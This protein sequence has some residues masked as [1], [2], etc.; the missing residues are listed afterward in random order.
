VIYP[1]P[2]SP[3]IILQNKENRVYPYLLRG[4]VIDRPDQVWCADITYIRMHRGWVYLMAIMDWFS[5]YVLAWEVSITLDVSFCLTAMARALGMG[6]P[7][8]FNTDQGSQFTSDGFTTMLEDIG[9]RISMDGKGRVSDNIFIERLW[10]TVKYEEVYLKDY[11]T[12]SEAVLSLGQYFV[13]YNE[14]RPHQ[15]L[16]YRTPAEVYG[17]KPAT[18]P[19]GAA[20]HAVAIPVALPAP[21]IAT[22]SPQGVNPP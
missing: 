2:R 9:I 20:K 11:Q 18:G 16:D 5:R 10:R 21:S 19:G 14:Q 1:K 15:S 13:F 6:T 22:A 8:I 17:A 3:G 4:L 12:V 7:E